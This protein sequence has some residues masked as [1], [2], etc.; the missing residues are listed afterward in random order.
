LR[1]FLDQSEVKPKP[2][3]TCSHGFSRARREFEFYF[4]L[5]EK[6]A[7]VFLTNHRAKQSITRITFDNWKMLLSL[8]FINW[9]EKVNW[10]WLARIIAVGFGFYCSSVKTALLH[11]PHLGS[12]NRRVAITRN[13][14]G[15]V[16]PLMSFCNYQMA[17]ATFAWIPKAESLVAEMALSFTF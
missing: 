8:G 11:S 10:L 15:L 6:V 13:S 14:Q 1:H 12:K 3:I 16:Q 7:R 4:W 17:V 2:I 5:V 9:V